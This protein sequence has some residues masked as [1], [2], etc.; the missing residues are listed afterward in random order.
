MTEAAHR[1]ATYEDVL[2]AHARRVAEVV[3][4]VLYTQPRPSLLHA[5]VTTELT[6]SLNPPY[7]HGRGGPG[8]WIF[9]IEPELHLGV[10]PDI[11]VPDL[12]GWRTARMPR[13]PARPYHTLAP[14]WVAEVLSPSTARFDRGAKLPVYAR[15]G[16]GH[17]WL[18][19]PMARTVEVLRLDGAG[20][21]L[22]GTWGGDDTARLEPFADVTFEL[23]LLWDEAEAQEDEQSP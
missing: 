1:R 21:R 2:A 4:G 20:Y 5:Q 12:A 19:D 13:V 23:R 17:V 18:L 6:S 16:V 7:R 3:D 22:V 9:L 10:E 15:E 11:L 8:G 14:D